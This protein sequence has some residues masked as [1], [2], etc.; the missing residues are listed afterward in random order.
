MLEA[1]KIDQALSDK[2]KE[3]ARI[4]RIMTE[5]EGW[6]EL[7]QELD[8]LTSAHVTEMINEDDEKKANQK[9]LILRGILM[10]KTMVYTTIKAGESIIK[11]EN[12]DTEEA[13]R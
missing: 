10:V 3:Q 5:G 9:R 13:S 8:D 6:K 1:D 7:M 11:S 12:E 2:I 4:Y